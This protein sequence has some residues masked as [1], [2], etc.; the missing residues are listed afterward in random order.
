MNPE[1]LLGEK[2]GL[3]NMVSKLSK[4]SRESPVQCSMENSCFSFI[5]NPSF[6]YIQF[7]YVSYF[8]EY[9]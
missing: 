3:N 2:K 8:G 6:L 1:T 5:L 7:N 4:I 9:I